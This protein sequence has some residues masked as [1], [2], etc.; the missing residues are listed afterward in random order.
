MKRNGRLALAEERGADQ[1]RVR[2]LGRAEHFLALLA[3]ALPGEGDAVDERRVDEQR[4]HAASVGG[5]ARY[6]GAA[7]CRSSA[8][9][10]R[11]SEPSSSSTL[12]QR[13]QTG[14]RLLSSSR[15]RMS[16]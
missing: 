3:A 5:R 9:T 7:A 15:L 14:N 1:Q 6:V 2:R 10:A 8:V 4:F 13:R 12:Q 16:T 11:R